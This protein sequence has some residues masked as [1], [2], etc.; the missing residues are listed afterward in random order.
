MPS[1]ARLASVKVAEFD[2]LSRD[3][4]KFLRDCSLLH[5][6]VSRSLGAGSTRVD[7][8]RVRRLRDRVGRL[9]EGRS[10]WRVTVGR[11]WFL[12][13]DSVP[14]VGE[15]PSICVRRCA[16]MSLIAD[17][18]IHGSSWVRSLHPPRDLVRGRFEGARRRAQAERPGQFPSLAAGPVAMRTRFGPIHCEG[19]SWRG[20]VVGLAVASSARYAGERVLL[21]AAIGSNVG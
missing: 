18:G 3:E 11:F 15:L 8:I 13:D 17:E 19:G 6:A 4:V 7:L 20:G 2:A 5:P 12:T 9:G 1:V 14:D 10:R 21:L 16:P